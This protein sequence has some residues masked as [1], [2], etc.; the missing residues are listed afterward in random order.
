[1]STRYL[2]CD[3]LNVRPVGGDITESDIEAI[4]G[5][6]NSNGTANALASTSD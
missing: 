1:M 5:Q 3:L 2:P 4:G 6:P